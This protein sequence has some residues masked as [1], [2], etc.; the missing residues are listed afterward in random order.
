MKKALLIVDMQRDFCPGGALPV[1]ECASAV[2]KINDYIAVFKEKGLP[3]F[4]SRDWHPQD[5]THFKKHGGKWPPHCVRET[6]GAAFHN[7]LDLDEDVIVISKG[8]GR[9]EDSY[10]VFLGRNKAGEDFNEIL[11]RMGI[12][13][14][15]V[16]GVATDYCVKETSL[17]ALKNG[18]NAYLLAD[19]IEG[20]EA[21]E[22]DIDKAIDEMLSAGV[23]KITFEE[24]DV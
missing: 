12:K 10:S 1:K 15:Y 17:D 18:Y 7:E 8:L 21:E 24:L 22:G 20:V 23:K 19:A 6:P 14:L 16:C 5:T 2:K 3:V 11:Q 13:E 4:A 9:D